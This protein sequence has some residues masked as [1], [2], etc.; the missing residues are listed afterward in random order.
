MRILLATFWA[1]P[2]LGGVWNYMTQLKNKLDS[3]GHQVDLLGYGHDNNYIHMV[4]Q[5]R[6]LAKEMLLP[7]VYSKLNQQNSLIHSQNEVVRY[8]ELQRYCYQIAAFHFGLQNYDVIHTQDV[9]STG[10]INGAKPKEVPLVATLHGSVAHEMRYQLKTIHKSPTSHLAR[11]YF[12]KLEYIGATSAE[13]T[14]VSNNWLKRIL[15]NEFLVPEGQVKVFPYGYNTEDFI[16]RIGEPCSL[17][18]PANKKVILYTGRLVELKG[19]H[20]LISALGQLKQ[21]RDDW[22]CWIVG[23]G[24]KK[25]ELQIQ[26]MT[27][28]LDKDILF[29]GKRDDVPSLLARA[30]LFVF[31]SLFDNQPLSVIEAQLAGKPV[32]VTDAGGLP[33]MVEHGVTRIIVPAGDTNALCAQMNL[34]LEDEAYRK[35]L[36]TNARN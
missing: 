13:Y 27:S 11:E 12:D 7:L 14:I 36:G 8:T 33:E 29:L 32:I 21:L 35:R 3:L 20:H 23:D 28:G 6:K 34:L 18:T 22:V 15:T 1:V 17:Q 24:E 16:R 30:D 4:T 19:I 26:S 5:D 25:A 9:I 31:P 10:C 2:H